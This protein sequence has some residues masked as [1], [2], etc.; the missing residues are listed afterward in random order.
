MLMRVCE[1]LYVCV[2]VHMCVCVCVCVYACETV[3]AG[4]LH[5]SGELGV[6]EVSGGVFINHSK[7]VNYMF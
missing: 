1:Y 3:P 7:E 5:L 6:G 4:F 2:C